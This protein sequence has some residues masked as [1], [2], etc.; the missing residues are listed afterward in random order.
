MK[1]SLL[2]DCCN[3]RDGPEIYTSSSNW[4]I[5]QFASTNSG[6]RTKNC[7]IISQQTRTGLTSTSTYKNSGDFGLGN[8]VLPIH[9][10][11]VSGLRIN[12]SQVHT[13]TWRRKRKQNQ[14]KKT[15]LRGIHLVIGLIGQMNPNYVSFPCAKNICKLSGW[16]EL[17]VSSMISRSFGTW[18]SHFLSTI[19]DQLG[20][21]G[22]C[23]SV[24]GFWGLGN[25]H[26]GI[27]QN[28]WL[29]L[30]IRCL[31]DLKAIFKIA[32][33]SEAY[34]LV[35]DSVCKICWISRWM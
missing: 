3:E 32:C 33:K 19:F 18:W 17:T 24:L 30:H 8:S 1:W 25:P 31:K 13:W 29:E 26:T 2:W 22:V 6:W 28:A 20:F 35:K 12:C 15:L 16:D 5:V 7:L 21:L 10:P 4:H 11:P 9:L 14:E 23:I 34:R 27:H